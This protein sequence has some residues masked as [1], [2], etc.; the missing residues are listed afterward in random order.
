[1]YWASLDKPAVKM[2]S[3]DGT[4]RVTLLSESTADYTGITLYNNVLYISDQSRRFVFY[5]VAAATVACAIVIRCLLLMSWLSVLLDLFRTVYPVIVML[6]DLLQIYYGVFV[7]RI[8][9]PIGR[10]AFSVFRGLGLRLMIMRLA[11][12]DIY[13]H[14]HSFISSDFIR[15]TLV[16]LE[17]ISVRDGAF[18]LDQ[19]DCDLSLTVFVCCSL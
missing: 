11:H 12:A 14:F 15:T 7:G 3:L 2:A 4:G 13:K 9:S 19:F 1:M 17:L 6:L 18:C 5:T 8:F 10:N 16:L